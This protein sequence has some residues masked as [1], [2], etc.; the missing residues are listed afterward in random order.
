MLQQ[1]TLLKQ[2]YLS[3]TARYIA[4]ESLKIGSYARDNCRV[5]KK[6]R[7]ENSEINIMTTL[8][9][10]GLHGIFDKLVF[11]TNGKGEGGK[12]ILQSCIKLLKTRD[13]C[14]PVA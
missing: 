11:V 8:R 14:Q 10:F 4:K 12:G 6:E 13:L 1:V 9:S 3:A 2:S 5:T 7:E